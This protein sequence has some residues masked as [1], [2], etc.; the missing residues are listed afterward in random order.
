MSSVAKSTLTSVCAVTLVALPSAALADP[1]PTSPVV[2]AVTGALQSVTLS[3]TAE[4]FYQW[5]F[6]E[7]SNQ[8]SNFLGFNNRHNTFTLSNV[9]LG[10]EWDAS[11]VVG[12]ITLQVGHTPDTYY[13]AEPSFPGGSGAN[14]T[15]PNLWKLVQQAYGGYRIPVGKGILITAGLFLS[16]IGPEGMLVKDNWNLSRSN[17]FFG[18]PFYHTGLRASYPIT[19]EWALSVAGYN[20]WNSVTDNNDEK[21]VSAQVTYTKPN[22]LALSMLYFGGVERPRRAPEGR[23]WRHLLDAHATIQ[24][25]PR[26]ALLAHANVGVEPNALGTSAWAA[27]ALYARVEVLRSLFVAARGDVFFERVARGPGGAAAPIFWPAE[28]VSSGTATVEAR[29]VDQVSFR[30]EYR[31]DHAASDM[32]FGGAVSEDGVTAPFVPNRS[33]Q[34][35]LTLGGAAWF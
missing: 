11:G 23:A 3:G 17:L 4:V 18:L 19:D 30:L 26:L 21:S 29:P 9:A 22:K 27:G 35:T 15:G 8:I 20:G 7:P 14:A 24:A 28:W 34:D 16:P 31:H 33:S 10:A 25:T 32:Y 2:N 12:K 1:A 6:N 5:S 13:A